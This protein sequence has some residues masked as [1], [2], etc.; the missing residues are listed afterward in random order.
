MRTLGEEKNHHS[1]SNYLSISL[2]KY[3]LVYNYRILL[4]YSIV[5]FILST[6]HVAL[7]VSELLQGFVYEGESA[8]GGP[9][10]FYRI[11]VFPKRKAIYIINVC[12]FYYFLLSA[13]EKDDYSLFY[14]YYLDASWRFPIG[15]SSSFYCRNKHILNIV[16]GVRSGEYTLYTVGTG[17]YALLVCVQ[18]V[19][20]YT[21]FR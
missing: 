5:M 19:L 9:A 15:T 14:S 17:L 16:L 3:S 13:F 4:A 11:N 6:T 12:P 10:A 18:L 2:L 20:Y 21:S 7:A 8:P 1:K